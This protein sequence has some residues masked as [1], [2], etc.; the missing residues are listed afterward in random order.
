MTKDKIEKVP[1]ITV[2]ARVKE[3]RERLAPEYMPTFI[4]IVE[5][6]NPY[7]KVVKE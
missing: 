1:S 7:A 6:S 5:F 2:T 3:K 4:V